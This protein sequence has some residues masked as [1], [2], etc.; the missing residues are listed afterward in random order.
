MERFYRVP[1]N[2]SVD[3]QH[4]IERRPVREQADIFLDPH[5]RGAF[6]VSRTNGWLLPV[7]GIVWS[8]TV[9]IA[10]VKRKKLMNLGLICGM[11]WPQH[12]AGELRRV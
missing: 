9:V 3:A 2:Y 7:P 6:P 10:A 11:A 5:C 4:R 8:Y 12:G 1:S